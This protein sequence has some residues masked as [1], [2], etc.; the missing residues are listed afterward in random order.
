MQ[1]VAELFV[2][3]EDQLG[4]YQAELARLTDS[5]WSPTIPPLYITITNFRLILVPQTRRPYPPASIPSNYITRV[6]HIGDQHRDGI[7]LA[8]RTGHEL[9]MFADLRNCMGLERDLKTM[10]TTPIRHRFSH[11]LAQRDISRLIR[12]V[13]GI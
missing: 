10:I 12:F 3:D 6:W 13:E 7:A 9:Y 4:F 2:R 1:A 5:G 8:L 11:H